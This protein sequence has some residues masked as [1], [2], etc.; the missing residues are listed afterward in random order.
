MEGGPLLPNRD[1]SDEAKALKELVELMARALVDSPEQV[2]VEA[3]EEDAAL[4]LRL[5]AASADIGRVIGKQGR[6]AKAM[7]TLLH[8]IAARTKRRAILEI[9][10]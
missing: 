7:R 6:T 5:R 2:S 8:A 10:E 4:V 3:A 9:L 1:P